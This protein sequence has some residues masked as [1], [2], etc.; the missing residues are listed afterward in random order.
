M[1]KFYI[2]EFEAGAFYLNIM[3]S[4]SSESPCKMVELSM[5]LL[6]LGDAY[7]VY[8]RKYYYPMPRCS[9]PF[10]FIEPLTVCV[11]QQYWLVPDEKWWAIGGW[12]KQNL[13]HSTLIP[14]VLWCDAKQCS[15]VSAFAFID[16]NSLGNALG[17][18]TGT[19]SSDCPLCGIPDQTWIFLGTRKVEWMVIAN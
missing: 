10:V 5:A 16:C 17:S 3:T 8:I 12:K 2:Y 6:V 13:P 9:C 18:K 15:Q 4:V 19:I 11:P 14:L 1:K 7:G